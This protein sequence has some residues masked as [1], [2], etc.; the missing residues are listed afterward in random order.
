MCNRGY[1]SAD[2]LKQALR[3]Q[4]LPEDMLDEAPFTLD[5]K[6]QAIG[7]GVPLPLGRAMARAVRRA[8]GLATVTN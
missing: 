6:F 5:G 7:N 1:K 8:L 4:G 3:D 2:K